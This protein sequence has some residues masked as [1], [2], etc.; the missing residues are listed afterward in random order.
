MTLSFFRWACPNYA[1]TPGMATGI[2]LIGF[3]L[4]FITASLMRGVKVREAFS[5]SGPGIPATTTHRVI[6]FVVGA[7]TLFEGAKIVFRCP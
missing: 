6:F 4:L 1:S 2:G 3:G 7:A 5:R